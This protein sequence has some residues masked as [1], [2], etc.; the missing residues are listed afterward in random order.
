MSVAQPGMVI[1]TKVPPEFPLIW[2]FTI[3]IS[4]SI[5]DQTNNIHEAT[6]LQST[7]SYESAT[8]C[9]QAMRKIVDIINNKGTP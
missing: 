7:E 2:K 8:E 1:P 3:V 4:E 5:I 6:I 9:K